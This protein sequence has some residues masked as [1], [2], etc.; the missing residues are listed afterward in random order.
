MDLSLS[1]A[2]SEER[3]VNSINS[4]IEKVDYIGK[5]LLLGNDLTIC[6]DAHKIAVFV[7]GQLSRVG[8]ARRFID[9]YVACIRSET[10]MDFA[11]GCQRI[12]VIGVWHY[13][14]PHPKSFEPYLVQKADASGR[15]TT[16]L[17][18]YS[19]FHFDHHRSGERAGV[20][21]TDLD[22]PLDA[23]EFFKAYTERLIPRDSLPDNVLADGH[24][25]GIL[26]SPLPGVV[27]P[28]FIYKAVGLRKF[29]KRDGQRLGADETN[30]FDAARYWEVRNAYRALAAGGPATTH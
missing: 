3:F 29:R 10:A 6:V 7:D 26:W 19:I 16:E 17:Y 20:T 13:N 30:G 9:R 24:P 1:D 14:G 25:C 18:R 23:V 21:I 15:V 8:Q 28:P 12:N 22:N 5:Q 27:C 2:A 4:K 11:A